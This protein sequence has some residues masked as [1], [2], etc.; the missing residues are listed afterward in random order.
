[1]PMTTHVTGLASSAAVKLRTEDMSGV[2]A[3]RAS[4]KPPLSILNALTVFVTTRPTPE[5][6]A[7]SVP[8]TARKPPTARTMSMMTLTSSW[9]FSI[10]EPTFVSTPSPLLIRSLTVGS[11]EFPMLSVTLWMRCLSRSKRSGSV[12]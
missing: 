2:S 12:S 5:I 11:R 10:H 8:P 9:F 3:P 4:A 6:R 7:I 1:M